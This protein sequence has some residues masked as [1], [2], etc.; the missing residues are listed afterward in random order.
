MYGQRY[1]ELFEMRGSELKFIVSRDPT[2]H[3][4][5]LAL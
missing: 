1:A 4:G 3:N 5:I 2:K